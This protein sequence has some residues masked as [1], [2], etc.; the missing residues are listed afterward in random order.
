MITI[1]MMMMMM[2]MVMM[3][4]MNDKLVVCLLVTHA[5]KNHNATAHNTSTYAHNTQHMH[6][7]IRRAC[8][9]QISK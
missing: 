2:M 7:F 5:H 1:L 6:I 3:V 8:G 4:M 9:M